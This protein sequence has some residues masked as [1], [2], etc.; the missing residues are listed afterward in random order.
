MPL[1][2]E[3]MKK[4]R[5][6]VVFML[7]LAIV[8]VGFGGALAADTGWMNPSA[9]AFDT[10]GDGDGFETTPEGA[11]DDEGSVARNANGAGDRHRYYDYGFNIPSSATIYGIE[12]R[13]DWY[14][15]NVDDTS[16]MDVELSWDGGSSWTVAKNDP[17]NSATEHTSILGG[18]T[19]AWGHTWNG[20]SFSNANFRVRLT[21]NSGSV[22]RDFYLDWVPVIVYYNTAPTVNDQTFNVGED[23]ANGTAAGTVVASDPDAGDTLTAR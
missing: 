16:S 22:V 3:T 8:L 9:D 1:K 19:D 10:G 20:D 11:Y 13:L 14:L 17:T 4:I 6:T 23:A 12:V 15:D 18:P 2:K 21:C 5:T 7:A